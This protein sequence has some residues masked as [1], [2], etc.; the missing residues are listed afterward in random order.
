MKSWDRLAGYKD[1]ISAV[2]MVPIKKGKVYI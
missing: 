1:E 2:K